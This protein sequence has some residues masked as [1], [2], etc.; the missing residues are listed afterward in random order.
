MNILTNNEKNVTELLKAL[1]TTLKEK[2][3]L[4]LNTKETG[5]NDSEV[6]KRRQVWGYNEIS[7]KKR[8]SVIKELLLKF[9]SPL[10]LTLLI[11][12]LVSG[13]LGEKI[14]AVIVIMMAILSVF[15]SFFQEHK[16]AKSAERLQ[17]MVRV[18][19]Q[20]IRNGGLVE[21]NLREVVPGDLVD[22]SAG[23]MVPADL[24]IIASNNL[25]INQSALN[26]ESF[27][28]EKSA[29]KKGLIEENIYDLETIALM[30][31]SVVSGT[32]QGI[33]INTGSKTEFAQMS[34][35]VITGDTETGFELGIKN[36]SLMMIKLILVLTIFIFL[37][38]AVLKHNLTEALLFSLAVAIGLAPEMLPM[39]VTINLTRGA[40]KMSKKKVITKRLDAI[41]NFG[42]MD[43][44]CTDKTGTLTIDQIVLV[45]HC[46]PQGL[47]N[48]EILKYAFINSSL[49][50][51]MNNLL[52]KAVIKHQSFD[53]SH[54][55]KIDEIPYD[56]MR[57]IM[58]VVIKAD[59]RTELIAK[60]A[61]EEIFKRCQSYEDQGQAREMNQERLAGL[62]KIYNDFS[63][64]GFRVLAVA[65]K[66]IIDEKI[67][68][69]N[70]DEADLILMG[71][72][73]FLDPPKPSVKES[74][75]ELNRLGIKLKILSG[76]NELVTSK[77]CHEVGLKD[78]GE[79]TG[80]EIDLLDDE[81]LK[82]VVE[83]KTIFAR[84]LP[85]QKERIIK[86]LQ[87][88]GHVVGFLGDGINDAPALKA[89]D[90]GISVD[91]AVDIAK[92][93]ADIILLDR[94]LTV[95]S[96][97]VK[98]G[99][100]TF[101]NTLKYIKMGA[102]SNFG[103]MFSMTGASLFLPFLPMLPTQILLN[104]FLY[105]LSQIT[106]PSDNV[107][108]D[109]LLKPRPWDIK[110]I[111]EFIL[112]IG[113]VSSIFDFITFA[114][115]WFIFKASPEL[116][117]TGWFVES[118]FTQTLVIYIIRTNKLPFINSRPSKVL[119]YSTLAVVIAGCLIPY[120]FLANIFG[121]EPLPFTYFTILFGIALSYLILTQI[122]KNWFIKKYGYE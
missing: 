87:Q 25:Y 120:T 22:L 57:K 76:D 85:L 74:I 43:I 103:N 89:A 71:F 94:N 6:V 65:Y 116:F 121:F 62:N 29:V 53:L 5:L 93:M 8:G 59:D 33:A 16:A 35:S 14:N 64:D 122:V 7:A 18:K 11:V 72:I 69:N 68:Y 13:F 56:F 30:G 118:L 73:A 10:V 38:N 91:N 109:Y 2:V 4:E 77:I 9:A 32:G 37:V 50:T 1:N 31:S 26:G 95:L 92:E 48:E 112:V 3:F 61:P 81:A 83:T 82:K 39:I 63:R 47:E 78:M 60:G 41:Q 90:V 17:A 102:S 42:A 21:V 106:I 84:V 70:E 117:H 40:I 52:D 20:V 46:D 107:D 67:K 34:K 12:A 105:D 101:A 49:Q 98:E 15:L 100:K 108:E 24:K 96:E 97:C 104:N 113:P 110:F 54:F 99:R 86:T 23:D 58:S 51:G 79:I 28:A 27:P 44:L 75:I 19:T 88:N 111:K 55:K 114:V 45:K 80:D 119:L 36:F 115:M 66:K